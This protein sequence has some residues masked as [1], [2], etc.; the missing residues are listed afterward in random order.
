MEIRS[1]RLF[2]V[3]CLLLLILSLG[4][5]TVFVI[6]TLETDSMRVSLWITFGLLLSF[7]LW[8]FGLLFG[9]DPGFIP[10]KDE[11]ETRMT[12]GLND[13]Y[14]EM[15]AL[16]DSREDL[17]FYIHLHSP[18]TSKTL[19]ECYSCSSLKPSISTAHCSECGRC[20][21]GKDHHCVFLGTCIGLRNR[22]QFVAFLVSTLVTCAVSFSIMV[23]ALVAEL[24]SSHWPRVGAVI[25]DFSPLEIGLLGAFGVLL[26]LRIFVFPFV[27]SYAANLEVLGYIFVFGFAPLI[28]MVREDH[29]PWLSSIPAYVEGMI[30]FFVAS[31]LYYQLKLLKEGSTIRELMNGPEKDLYPEETE[32]MMDTSRS[33]VLMKAMSSGETLRF[34]LHGFWFSQYPLFMSSSPIN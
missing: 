23:S 22:S 21:V 26:L 15:Y 1:I 18:A 29:L 8:T 25:S 12:E 28:V 4:A 6:K 31:N 19:Y 16:D 20:V 30:L 27:L 5:A 2:L 9:T 10:R 24:R 33:V 13:A 7:L 14:R 11:M 32:P 3:F 17:A 34:A